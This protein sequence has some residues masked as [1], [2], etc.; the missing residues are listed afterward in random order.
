MNI[1]AAD[2]GGTKTRL[3]Y[4]ELDSPGQIIHEAR[5]VSGD[6]KSFSELLDAFLAQ[7][8]QRK[9]SLDVLSLALPGVVAGDIARLTNLPWRIDRAELVTHYNVSQVWFIND[10]QAAAYGIAA[11]TDADIVALSP[12]AHSN[13]ATRVVLGAGTGLGLAWLQFERGR[14]QAYSS[15]G[16]HID[17]APA[18][19]QQAELLA[20]LRERHRADSGGHVSYERIL[21]GA[22]LVNLYA[23]CARQAATDMDAAWVHAQANADHPQAQAAMKLFVQIYGSYVGNIALLYKPEGG[24]Y[25]AGGIA[26]KIIDWMRSADFSQAYLNKGRMRPL[27]SSISVNLITN[28]RIGVIGALRYAVQ[29]QQVRKNDN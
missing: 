8:K 26:G 3:V 28:E 27:A 14:P 13:D 5:L 24:I 20:Y 29:K 22:G 10:F 25:I 19:E 6:Y 23:F 16:G 9:V 21:S 2:V 7:L 18:D 11:M 17:F 4:A 1:I 12:G 15:E